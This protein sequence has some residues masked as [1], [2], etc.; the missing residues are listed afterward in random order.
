MDVEAEMGRFE[1][2][3]ETELKKYTML[4]MPTAPP[5]KQMTVAMDCLATCCLGACLHVHTM[6]EVCVS[7]FASADAA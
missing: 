7:P 1:M 6:L 2:A 4:T 5:Q 3:L